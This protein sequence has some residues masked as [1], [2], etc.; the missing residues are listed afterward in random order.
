MIAP[1]PLSLDRRPDPAA[2]LAGRR[3]VV[4]GV[5]TTDSIAFATA[6]S[7]QLAGAE[8]VLTALARDRERAEEAARELPERPPILELDLTDPDQVAA[9]R[10]ELDARWG[11]IDGALHA[12]AFAPREALAGDFLAA[13]PEAVERA[14][15]AFVHKHPALSAQQLR[16]LQM[17]Q[18]HIAQHGGIEI[19]RLYEPPFTTL[20]ANGVDGVFPSGSEVDDLID[21][22][23]QFSLKDQQV[24]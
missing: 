9:V 21:I 4:T 23:S 16:F 24:S 14:F 11:G 20:H 8:V 10:R 3:L 5:A 15:T 22:L 19:D 17:V 6:R 12:V 7:A 18:N 13:G 1:E 2:P